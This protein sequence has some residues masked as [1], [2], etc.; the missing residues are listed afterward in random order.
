MIRMEIFLLLLIIL[1][2]RLMI[3]MVILIVMVLLHSNF[4][5]FIFFI[6]IIM[7]PVFLGGRQNFLFRLGCGLDT[8]LLLLLLDIEIEMRDEW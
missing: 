6:I 7:V 1:I 3:F 4:M 2:D 5:V 8:W